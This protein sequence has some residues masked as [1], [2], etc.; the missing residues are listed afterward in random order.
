MKKPFGT[1]RGFNE[2]PKPSIKKV[3]GKW[4]YPQEAKGFYD[5]DDSDDLKIAEKRIDQAKFHTF[6]G[7]DNFK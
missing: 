2:R 5:I 1:V 4:E 3:R 7:R 6:K